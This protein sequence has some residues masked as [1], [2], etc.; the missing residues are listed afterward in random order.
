MR[1]AEYGDEAH[2][3]RGEGQIA[4]NAH[5][6]A[7]N[8]GRRADIRLH[9]PQQLKGG[10][11]PFQKALPF[12]RNVQAFPVAVEQNGV[13]RLFQLPDLPADGGGVTVHEVCRLADTAGLRCVV[14]AA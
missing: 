3:L 7:Q 1:L 6:A 4:G 9:A 11:G 14:E 5:R 2:H 8:A 13:Q 12:R 10:N